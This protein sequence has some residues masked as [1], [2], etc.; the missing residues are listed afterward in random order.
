MMGPVLGE[1]CPSL[2]CGAPSPFRW[3]HP[4]PPAGILAC[5]LGG[6][7]AGCGGA[8]AECQPG[9]CRPGNC[10]PRE[11]T[12]ASGASPRL[13]R[14]ALQSSDAGSP[15]KGEHFRWQNPPGRRTSRGLG[16]QRR[17]TG[18]RDSMC[19]SD[20]SKQGEAPS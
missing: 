7:P 19:K 5:P 15:S 14:R 8:S 10:R 1:P 9:S 3:R 11:E 16:P 12:Q 18:R 13:G 17:V 20:V 2:L 4:C 6:L